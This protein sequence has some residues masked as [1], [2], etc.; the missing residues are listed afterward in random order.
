VRSPSCHAHGQVPA[1]EHNLNGDGFM[2]LEFGVFDHLDR[3]DLPL[4]DYYEQRLKVIEVF[5]RF[6][7][8]AYHVAEHH[9]TPLGMAPSPSV[10]L[11]AIAQRTHRLRFGTFVYAL[12]VHHPLRVLEEICML[13]HMSRGRLEI[14]FGRGSVPFEISYYGQNAEDR[15][16]IYAERLELILKAFS[17]RT[18][19]WNGRYDRFENV[20]MELAPLQ[21]PHPPLWYGAHSPESAERAARK[22]LNIVTNDMPGNARAIVGR[23]RQVWREVHPAATFPK[24]GIVRFIVV[25]ESDFE[26]LE[27]ARRSYLR[28]RSSFNYLSEMHGTKPDSPLNVDSFDQLMDQGQAIAGSPDTVR[29]AL[30]AQVKDS[31]ANYIVG[32]F[33]F[34]DLTFDEMCRSVELFAKQVMPSLRA[35]CIG[36]A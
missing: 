20:P 27:C 32:Q 6:G 14:G 15:Q 5:E 16:L 36:G 35:A 10:F 2:T 8:Y 26:A 18:L 21:K 31:E 19:T 28:W 3:N 7:F 9:F 22:G 12:P 23:Y 4:S 34:G 29:S 30:A 24:M 25:A 13:D 11:S 33:C 1:R 17:V